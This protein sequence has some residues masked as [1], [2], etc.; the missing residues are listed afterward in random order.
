[1]AVIMLLAF[2]DNWLDSCAI[3]LNFVQQINPR[4]K[5]CQRRTDHRPPAH[6]PCSCLLAT[7]PSCHKFRNS[8][9]FLVY[10]VY[11]LYPTTVW[12]I[13]YI[14]CGLAQQQGLQGLGF[15]QTRPTP[16]PDLK[17]FTIQAT[18]NKLN[19][20]A[21]TCIFKKLSYVHS[22]QLASWCLQ[23]PGCS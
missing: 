13:L 6:D 1:M 12:C 20:F 4:P 5:R 19:N 15:S 17:T 11:S 7:P 16:P 22:R 2:P 14:L 3:L 21:L 23:R 18:T 8:N 9:E 10:A